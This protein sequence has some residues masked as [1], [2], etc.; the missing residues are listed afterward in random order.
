M[1]KKEP[2]GQTYAKRLDIGD[3]V[4][5]SEWS[6]DHNQYEKSIGILTELS[7]ESI[8][9]RLVSMAHITDINKSK[10]YKV[11]TINLKV[12]SKSLVD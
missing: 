10:T 9:G 6:I 4:E 8:S 7:V 2:F 1:E 3:L 11:F 12:I 5:W